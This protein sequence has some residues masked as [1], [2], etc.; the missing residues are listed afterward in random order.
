MFPGAGA[1]AGAPKPRKLQYKV[2]VTFPT[3][4]RNCRFL[5]QICC[6]LQYEI[7]L[8]GLRSP[9][10]PS[11]APW[12]QIASRLHPDRIQI[13]SRL[14]IVEALAQN[15]FGHNLQ[16]NM[17]PFGIP[18]TGPCMGFQ[19]TTLI[20]STLGPILGPQDLD[21]GSGWAGVLFFTKKGTRK[22]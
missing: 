13:A 15:G 19:Y 3:L 1:D 12:R 6:K 10:G 14:P 21:L 18:T 8:F 20:C 4:Q 2:D 5:F 22:T 11:C 16:H 17:A 9:L 7:N